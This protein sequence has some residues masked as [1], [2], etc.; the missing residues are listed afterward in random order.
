ME[1]N[2][3][4][5]N[6]RKEYKMKQMKLNSSFEKEENN[7]DNKKKSQNINV[8][9]G[10]DSNLENK[11]K[12]QNGITSEQKSKKVLSKNITNYTFRPVKLSNNINSFE[13]GDGN[14]SYNYRNGNGRN[15]QRD[16][17]YE[18]RRTYNN[19]NNSMNNISSKMVNSNFNNNL[20]IFT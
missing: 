13:P 16:F 9:N 20:S 15:E 14:N 5:T 17:K 7:S 3:L 2:F 10:I 6:K 11:N 12:Y 1:K 8:I 4:I 19:R 18:S